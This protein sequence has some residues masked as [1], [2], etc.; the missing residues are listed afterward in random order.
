MKKM[1]LM[2]SN[3]VTYLS[4]QTDELGKRVTKIAYNVTGDAEAI[5]QYVAD[6]KARTGNEPKRDDA[7]GNYLFTYPLS[8]LAQIGET[9][10]LER[11]KN[12][13]EQGNHNWFPNVDEHRTEAQAFSG[14]LKAAWQADQMAETKR[15]LKVCAK[16]KAS[17][18]AAVAAKSQKADLSKP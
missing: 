4:K 8:Y 5:A 9:G 3:V 1:I 12:P 13:D 18:D 6:F 7:T 11:T 2:L 16:N 14:E 10:K 15:L 17:H